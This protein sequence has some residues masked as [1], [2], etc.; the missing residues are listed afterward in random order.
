VDEWSKNITDSKFDIWNASIGEGSLKHPAEVTLF[1]IVAESE[2]ADNKMSVVVKQKFKNKEE[3]IF[4][5]RQGCSFD[6]WAKKL[7]C[8]VFIN[9]SAGIMTVSAELTDAKTKKVLSRKSISKE[10]GGGR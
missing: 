10:Y 8:A 1:V 2:S 3:T 9:E 4:E 5:G 6:K 7:R